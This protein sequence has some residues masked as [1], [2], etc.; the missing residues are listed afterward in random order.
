MFV[1]KKAYGKSRMKLAKLQ[2]TKSTIR[3]NAKL[4]RAKEPKRLDRGPF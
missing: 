3:F 4:F 2:E 1:G